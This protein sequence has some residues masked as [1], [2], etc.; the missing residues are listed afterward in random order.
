MT[1]V[2]PGSAQLVAG[3]RRRRPDRAARLAE[4]A[5]APWSCVVLLGLVW[6]GFV[7]WLRATPSSSGF[8]R[9]LLCVL[10]VGWALLFIDAWR[11]GQP[12]A[13][14][15]RSSGSRWSGSTACSASRSPAPCC[16]PRTWWRVQKDFISAMFG[17]GA[18]T[19]AHARPLQRAAAR[20]RLR[21]DRWGLRPDSLTVASIDADTG[22]TVLFGLPRNMLNFP[23]AKGS[24]M[25]EQFPDGYDCGGSAS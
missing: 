25:A 3:R 1:L 22:K 16:S 11:L 18:A 24:I 19:G 6:H 23:F 7:F 17:D 14:A 9:L 10:A 2:L 8:I 13:A 20:R 12:L 5:S 4:R 21:R 15:C